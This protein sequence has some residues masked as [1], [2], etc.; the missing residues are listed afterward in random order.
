MK[1]LFVLLIVSLFLSLSFIPSYADPLK[2]SDHT[3]SYVTQILN[4]EIF[5][6][7]KKYAKDNFNAKENQNILA[8]E[9]LIII[10]KYVLERKIFFAFPP[11]VRIF[12]SENNLR[13]VY[14]LEIKMILHDG[15]ESQPKVKVGI[16]IGKRFIILLVDK[17]KAIV[18]T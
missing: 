12:S 5:P 17:T 13:K 3:F 15:G 1:K 7:I 9:I 18:G 10:K 16:L 6:E 4:N 14:I 2:P 8:N 11:I